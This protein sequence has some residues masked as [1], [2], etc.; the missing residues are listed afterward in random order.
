MSYDS[1]KEFVRKMS[2]TDLEAEIVKLNRCVSKSK[3][4]A[5]RSAWSKMQKIALDQQRANAA[6]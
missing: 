6:K 5:A 2:A 4:Q 3:T 1:Y